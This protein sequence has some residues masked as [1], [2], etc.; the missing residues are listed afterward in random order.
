MKAQINRELFTQKTFDSGALGVMTSVIHQF[1]RPGR[2]QASVQKNDEQTASFTFRVDEAA[3]NTQLN[4]DLAGFTRRQRNDK[5]DCCCHDDEELVVS[6]KGYVVFYVSTGSGYSVKAGEL[7]S[8]KVEF[9]SQTLQTGDL[10]ALSLLE[11]TKYSLTNLNNRAS[12]EINVYFSEDIAK[13][14]KNL[15][16]FY[17]EASAEGFNPPQ[18]QLAATQG[19]VFR[20]ADGAASRIVIEKRDSADAGDEQPRPA[21]S[22][23]KITRQPEA[24]SA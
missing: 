24:Q 14:L 6:S 18:L 8:E 12:G 7:E 11:P 4:I 16:T 21:K 17:V 10:F 5:D 3:E 2:Y 22:W 15:E 9:D 1:S 19:L 20:V 13:K 23:R